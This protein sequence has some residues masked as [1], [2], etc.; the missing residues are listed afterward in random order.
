MMTSEEKVIARLQFRA[1]VSALRGFEFQNFFSR[2]MSFARSDFSPVKPQGVYGD[3]KNDG[4]EPNLGRYY[5]VYAPV[6]FDE[7]KAVTKIKE[8]FAGLMTMWGNG[9]VY[10]VGIQEFY[11]VV[12]DSYSITTGAYPTTYATLED[13]RKTN[14]LKI[15]RPFLTKDLEDVFLSLKDDQIWSIV[16]FPPNPSKIKVLRLDLVAEV[17]KHIVENPIPRSLDQSL[18]EEAFERK[19]KFNQLKLSGNLLRVADYRR[20]TIE[21][22][23]SSNSD[24]TRQHVRD[25][26]KAIYENSKSLSL[27]GLPVSATASDQQFFHILHE[28][29]PRPPLDNSRLRNELEEAAIVVMAYF[30]E[31]CDIFEEPK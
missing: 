10:S 18:P 8:D 22:Y 9:L 1:I 11:F 27:D 26:L 6:E 12:N 13:L 5:Q 30:F 19:I 20:G 25:K 24:F 14:G 4:H 17:V 3:W 28:I 29:V 2:V 31:S 21:Q 15:S 16:G 7:G 23:F